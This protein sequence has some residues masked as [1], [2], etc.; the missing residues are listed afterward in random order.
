M[1]KVKTYKG[2]VI[3]ETNQQEQTEG[4]KDNFIVFKKDEWSMGEGLRYDE[5]ECNTIDHCIE[6]IDSY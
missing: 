6:F 5:I 2:F 3:A 4:Y 1:K